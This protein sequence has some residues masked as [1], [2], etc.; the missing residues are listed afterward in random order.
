MQYTAEQYQTNKIY[1]YIP[2]SK[3][4]KRRKA[5]NVFEEFPSFKKLPT[6]RLSSKPVIRHIKQ[7]L[8]GIELDIAAYRKNW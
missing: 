5:W 6:H 3:L 7:C 2:N 8:I 4:A 1:F